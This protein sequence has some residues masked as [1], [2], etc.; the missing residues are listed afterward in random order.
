MGKAFCIWD[1]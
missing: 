1:F